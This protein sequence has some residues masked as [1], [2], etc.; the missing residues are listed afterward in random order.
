VIGKV[1]RGANASGLLRYLYGPGRANE[2]TD[3]HLVAGFYDPA[4]LEADRHP[5]GSPDTRRLAGLLLQPIAAWP[6]SCDKPVWHCSVRATPGDRILSDTEWAGVAQEVMDR[7]GLAPADDDEAVRWVAVRH[8]PDHIHIVATLARQDG[9]R[10]NVWNDFFKVRTA[11]QSAERRL[12]LQRTAPADRTAAKRPTRAETEQAARN[13]WAEA[14]RITLRREVSTAAAAAS[15]EQ[16]FFARLR[17]A[18]VLVRFR[19]STKTPG[20]IT[21]YAVALPQHTTSAGGVVWF[22]GG[23]LA[24]DLTLPKLRRRWDPKPGTQPRNTAPQRIIPAEGRAAYEHVA[25]Q[26][27]SAADHIRH[28][29]ATDPARAADAA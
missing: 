9:A 19:E 15:T 1:T 24:P 17:D 21:G 20:E 7:T 14:P 13:G 23:K 16:E 4:Y 12:G 25:R 11:C 29:A 3:P 28:R 5:D 6:S 2:H 27:R 18:G 22:G 26:A 10:P 8:A